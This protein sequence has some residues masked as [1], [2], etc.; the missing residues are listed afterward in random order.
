M[1]IALTLVLAA[2]LT[3]T[4]AG[5]ADSSGVGMNGRIVYTEQANDAPFG[6]IR[7]ANADG[8]GAVVL[9]DG[10]STRSGCPTRARCCSSRHGHAM[11]TSGP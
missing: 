2:V 5:A 1:K 4:R 7:A 8:T 6:Q 10:A 9:V 3:A 11:S